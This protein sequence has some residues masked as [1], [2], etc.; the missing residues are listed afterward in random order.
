MYENN[1]QRLVDKTMQSMSE[2]DWNVVKEETET[3]PR[4][5]P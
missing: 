1:L 2:N 3:T 5:F 4:N